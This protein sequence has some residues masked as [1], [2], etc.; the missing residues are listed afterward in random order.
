M[1]IRDALQC[2]VCG[3][4]L[5]LSSVSVG[6]PVVCEQCG[7]SVVVQ[8]SYGTLIFLVSPV[9]AFALLWFAG[10]RSWLLVLGT[11]VGL[12]PVQILLQIVVNYIMPP[13]VTL[14]QRPKGVRPSPLSI[15][16]P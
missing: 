16:K 5:D 12:L 6:K 1:L 2:Q 9:I 10:V 3:F 4:S 13:K 11:I 15:P 7:S 14:A 8:D